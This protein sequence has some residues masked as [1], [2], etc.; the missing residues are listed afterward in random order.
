MNSNSSSS[1]N[2]YGYLNT[3]TS[4]YKENNLYSNA[5]SSTS[6]YGVAIGVE[7][8]NIRVGRG[9]DLIDINISGGEKAVGLK[10]S[11]LLTGRGNDDLNIS[12]ESN[13]G[14][15]TS[16]SYISNRLWS[17]FEKYLYSNFNEYS[18]F[19]QSSYQDQYSSSEL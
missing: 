13:G 10:K 19:Q 4:N 17:G 3:R 16:S 14:R 1:S 8:S 6:S 7:D 11:D 12:V 9:N 15:S 2:S 5:Y 18:N